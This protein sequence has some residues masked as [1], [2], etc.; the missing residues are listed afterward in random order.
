MKIKYVAS[1]I[2]CVISINLF[3]QIK[4]QKDDYAW[5]KFNDINEQTFELD[6]YKSP[7]LREGQDK[8]KLVI[9][10]A[11]GGGLRASAFTI[12]VLLGLD[13]LLY[14]NNDNVSNEIDYFSTVSGGGW[15]AGTFIAHK[16][17]CNKFK[18]QL[19]I[20]DTFPTYS[21]FEKYLAA[22]AD[23][24]YQK[25]Q[26]QYFLTFNKNASGDVMMDRL[27]HGYLGWGFRKSVE[28]YIYDSINKGKNVPA[29]NPDNVDEIMLKDVFV[30]KT[31]SNEPTMP[32]LIANTTN[33]DNFMIVPFTPDRLNHWGIKQY[34][35]TTSKGA[36]SEPIK[37][38]SVIGINKLLDV[39]LSAGLKASS[40]VN[41]L[42]SSSNFPSQKEGV[43]YTLHLVDG[44]SIDNF[45]LHTAKAILNQESI[46][47]KEKRILIIIDASASGI[48]T[49]NTK[50][51][52]NANRVYSVGRLNPLAVP[53]IQYP[54][55]RERISQMEKDYDCKILYFGTECLLDPKLGQGGVIPTNLKKSEKEAEKIF[56]DIYKKMI[57]DPDYFPK[58]VNMTD[59]SLL[60]AYISQKIST[61][62]SAKKTLSHGSKVVDPSETEGYAKIMML[63]GRAVVQLKTDEIKSAFNK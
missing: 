24:K 20:N 46:Q 32:M 30:L 57:K 8:D 49:T 23:R 12:G 61:W 60:Y 48:S 31:A 22:W 36:L 52:S 44:G 10:C 7:N 1:Q 37:A 2:L 51:K 50:N 18:N 58:N 16:Y 26:L 9:V 34:R 55:N 4:V 38:S 14:K 62:F 28:K 41:G 29:F 43:D 25:Y 39:P 47:Q 21:M 3:C 6:K 56:Y 42:I 40:C 59:R 53:D 13:T 27:N 33:I 45:G 5:K 19:K 54:I 11:S 17:Q 35:Y 15:G 63:A